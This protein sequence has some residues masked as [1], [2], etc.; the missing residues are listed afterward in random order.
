M[1]RSPAIAG[2]V[3]CVAVIFVLIFSYLVIGMDVVAPMLEFFIEGR[4][5]SGENVGV[6][7]AVS[8]FIL[9]MGYMLVVT[10]LVC[11]AALSGWIISKLTAAGRFSFQGAISLFRVEQ[12]D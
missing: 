12:E 7:E 3:S 5:A 4:R 1:W 6:I 8:V 11:L 10:L 9:V 2:L